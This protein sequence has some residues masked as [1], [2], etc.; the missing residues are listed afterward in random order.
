MICRQSILQSLPIRGSTLNALVQAPFAS[1]AAWAITVKIA[2]G[3]FA[4]AIGAIGDTYVVQRALPVN[5]ARDGFYFG[6]ITIVC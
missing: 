6:W 5:T 2:R 4:Y 1:L 3:V